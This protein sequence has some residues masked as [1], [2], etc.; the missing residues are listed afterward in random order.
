M[1]D[2][3]LLDVWTCFHSIF[4]IMRKECWRL[5]GDIDLQ[6]GQHLS[7]DFPSNISV[8]VIKKWNKGSA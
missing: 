6:S 3:L 5:G 8:T 4:M 7:L 1:A 2:H